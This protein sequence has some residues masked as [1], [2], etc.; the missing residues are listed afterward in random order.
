[1]T[2][3]VS[4]NDHIPD[5]IKRGRYDV[6]A[7]ED[8]HRKDLCDLPAGFFLPTAAV[9]DISKKVAISCL[10]CFSLHT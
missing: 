9:T 10:T 3:N 7:S 8:Q 4:E 6:I 1:M 5:D 2:K